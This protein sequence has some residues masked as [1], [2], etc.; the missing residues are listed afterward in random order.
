MAYYRNLI[1]DF[2][3][4][5]NKGT[6]SKILNER[7]PPNQAGLTWEQNSIRDASVHI[8]KQIK[9]DTNRSEK[10]NNKNKT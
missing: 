2:K 10:N 7:N 6:H 8:A 4:T 5:S 9:V 3:K 1:A